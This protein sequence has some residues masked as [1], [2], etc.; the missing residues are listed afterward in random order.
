MDSYCCNE[1]GDSIQKIEK[2]IAEEIYM[3]KLGVN[4]Q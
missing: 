3:E 1:A 4:K 2:I